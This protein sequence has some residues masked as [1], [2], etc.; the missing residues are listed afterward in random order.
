MFIFLIEIINVYIFNRDI[1]SFII[2]YKK[3]IIYNK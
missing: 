3:V 2:F 1:D